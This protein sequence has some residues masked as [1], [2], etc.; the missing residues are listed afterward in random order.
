MEILTREY[1]RI[2][3]PLS[4]PNV[5]LMDLIKKVE[6][7]L[8]KNMSFQLMNLSIFPG[9]VGFYFFKSSMFYFTVPI[10]YFSVS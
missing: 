8:S 7:E 1:Q 4:Q 2:G 9:I 3:S 5:T 10:V 6:I